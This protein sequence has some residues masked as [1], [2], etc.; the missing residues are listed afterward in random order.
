MK[1]EL[2]TVIE[3]TQQSENVEI[4]TFDK[5]PYWENPEVW[6]AYHNL[7]L[8]NAG[9][10]DAFFPYYKGSPFY[11]PGKITDRNLEK[12]V[13]D[14]TQPFIDDDMKDRQITYKIR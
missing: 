5:Y 1:I 14:F 7:S 3:I 8:A 13:A 10:T 9:F 11:E 4:P 12:I 2:V 6:Y